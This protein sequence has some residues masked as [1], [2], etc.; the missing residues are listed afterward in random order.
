MMEKLTREEK[1]SEE[2]GGHYSGKEEGEKEEAVT[3]CVRYGAQTEEE[4]KNEGRVGVE[5]VLEMMFVAEFFARDFIKVH[6]VG[7][8]G[9]EITGEGGGLG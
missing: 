6:E 4:E 7:A 2:G 1:I 3:E 9:D 5:G 8:I